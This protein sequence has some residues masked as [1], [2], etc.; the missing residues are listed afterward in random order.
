ML[1]AGLER[2]DFFAEFR[3]FGGKGVRKHGRLHE[4]LLVVDTAGGSLPHI[5]A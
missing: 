3:K 1:V 4:K 2:M 5:R